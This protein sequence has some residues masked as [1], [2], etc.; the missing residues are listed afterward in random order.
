MHIY[1][2]T[3]CTV[4]CCMYVCT[5]FNGVNPWLT[6]LATINWMLTRHL[7]QFRGRTWLYCI[8]MKLVLFARLEQYSMR[9][10]F[11]S[12]IVD[13]KSH[14]VSIVRV[15]IEAPFYSSCSKS[16]SY[17]ASTPPTCCKTFAIEQKRHLLLNS[18]RVHTHEYNMLREHHIV[19]T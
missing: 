7:P 9:I 2:Y 19:S 18:I 12:G 3:Y 11:E 8:E 4:W 10:H 15:L 1:M 13:P 6:P 17:T 5:L 16:Q 14:C